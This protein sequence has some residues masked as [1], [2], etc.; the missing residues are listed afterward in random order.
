MSTQRIQ[1]YF[2][3]LGIASRRK[4]E[5]WIAQG[6]VKLN[7]QTVTEPGTRFDPT[8]DRITLDKKLQNKDKKYYYLFNKPVGIVTVNAKKNET[9]ILDITN[10]PP[11]V[12]TV[13]R[14][15]KES[16]GLII[17]TND[18]VISRRLIEPQFNHEKEYIVAVNK[19]LNKLAIQKLQSPIYIYGQKTKPAKVKQLSRHK[20]SITLTEGKNRQI[21]RLCQKAGYQVKS[22][23]RVRILNLQLASLRPGKL[24]KLSDQELNKLHKQLGLE[25]R[26]TMISQLFS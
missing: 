1:K 2:S 9:E 6:F 26:M 7:N 17:L 19:S 24:R 11:G 15:D 21:R 18:G 22:L 23:I 14:L 4:T 10:T 16:G 13:G 20:F 8:K 5:E 25:N 12:V 3:D